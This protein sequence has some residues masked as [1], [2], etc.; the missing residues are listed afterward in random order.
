M[1]DTDDKSQRLLYSLLSTLTPE[2][3]L[4]RMLNLCTFGRQMMLADIKLKYP[5]A[6]FAQIR[7]L[8]AIRVLGKE[9]VEEHS[10]DF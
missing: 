8:F 4:S 10:N 7:K 5:N 1:N 3:R 2:E 9:F 6:D